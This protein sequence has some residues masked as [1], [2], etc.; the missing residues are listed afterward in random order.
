[1]LG[2]R[3]GWS[4]EVARGPVLPGRLTSGYS[5]SGLTTHLTSGTLKEWTTAS[6]A[7][8]AT[9]QLLRAHFVPAQLAISSDGVNETHGKGRCWGILM[10]LSTVTP[11]LNFTTPLV[12]WK[13]VFR[14]TQRGVLLPSLSTPNNLRP[15]FRTAV[16]FNWNSQNGILDS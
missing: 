13:K 8:L 1:M 11:S 6:V 12:G 16:A 10:K 7:M 15:R 14:T 5:T 4:A 9:M 3:R 2:Q